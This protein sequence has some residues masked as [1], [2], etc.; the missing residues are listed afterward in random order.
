MNGYGT[1]HYEDGRAYLGQWK[2]GEKS[3][4]G[5][6]IYSDGVRYHGQHREDKKCGYGIYYWTDGRKYEGY[7]SKGKQHG[8]GI[9]TLTTKN[10]A[11]FGLWEQGKRK[12]WFNEEQKDAIDRRQLNL[13]DFYD[14][15]ELS[16]NSSSR[17]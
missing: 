16:D 15:S 4:Y 6:F 11:R 12:L 10:E 3:G 5:I 7:W 9:Y 2:E 14:H 8:I 1:H 17:S 13:A